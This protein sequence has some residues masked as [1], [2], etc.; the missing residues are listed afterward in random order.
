MEKGYYRCVYVMLRFK[1]EAGIGSKEEQADVE[2]DP[3]EEDMDDVNLDDEMERHWVMV[4]EDNAGGVDD[5]K[6]LLHA[7]RWDIYVNKR[8]KLVK[9]GYLVEVFI[10]DKKKFIWEVVD[11]HVIEDPTDHEEIGLRGLI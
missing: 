11:D 1:N 2:G 7:K 3:Y 6:T 10:H 9:G 8:G 4:F 5:E